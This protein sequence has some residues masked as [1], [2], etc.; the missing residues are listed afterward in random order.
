MFSE[1]IKVLLL[2]H[3]VPLVYDL[4]SRVKPAAELFIYLQTIVQKSPFLLFQGPA[5]CGPCNNWPSAMLLQRTHTGVLILAMWGPQK[6]TDPCG[7][8]GESIPSG[9][10]DDVPTD[11]GGGMY[12]GHMHS[13]S[14]GGVGE[15]TLADLHDA[16]DDDEGEGQQLAGGEHVLH[17]G[18]PPHTRAVHP[19]QQH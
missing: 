16:H 8:H 4:K 17:P 1:S 14:T 3:T 7:V 12:C 5:L 10:T 15:L 11:R 13:G 19:C 9:M 6:L 18:G 2:S